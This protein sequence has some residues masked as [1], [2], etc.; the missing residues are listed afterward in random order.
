[1]IIDKMDQTLFIYEEFYIKGSDRHYCAFEITETCVRKL[2]R[3]KD[4]FMYDPQN[5]ITMTNSNLYILF[6]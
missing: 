2:I 6:D 3:L 4:L 1:M 5:V